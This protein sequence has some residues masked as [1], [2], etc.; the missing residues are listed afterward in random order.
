MFLPNIN[1]VNLLTPEETFIS[2]DSTF[3]GSRSADDNVSDCR[4][5]S[6]C[7]YRG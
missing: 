5:M 4:C 1:T 3:K 6:D 2:C 7:R